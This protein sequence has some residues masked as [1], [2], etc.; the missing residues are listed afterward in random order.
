MKTIK[1]LFF[2]LALTLTVSCDS[3]VKAYDFDADG[4]GVEEWEILDYCASSVANA[5][6]QY[7]AA[8]R[9]SGLDAVVAEGGYTCIIP[10]NDAFK[11]FLLEAGYASFEDVPGPVWREE[12]SYLIFAGDYRLSTMQAGESYTVASL[13]GEEAPI[14]ISR[15]AEEKDYTLTINGIDGLTKITVYS[16]DYLFKNRIVGQMVREM[17]YYRPTTPAASQAP[18][19]FDGD[20]TKQL[21][22]TDDTYIYVYNKN[23]TA[24][25]NGNKSALRI[26]NRKSYYAY[27]LLRFPM[28][29]QKVLDRVVK[30]ELVMKIQKLGTA[31]PAGTPNVRVSVN[32]IN[33]AACGKWTEEDATWDSVLVDNGLTNEELRVGT[34]YETSFVSPE[35]APSVAAP[36][37]VV[38]DITES[39][40]AHKNDPTVE[41]VLFNTSD[42]VN[43]SGAEFEIMDKE[44]YENDKNDTSNPP[45]I[46][47]LKGVEVPHFEVAAAQPLVAAVGEA[48][49]FNSSTLQLA[50]LLTAD[51]AYTR[52]ENL[53]LTLES[54]PE[55]GELTRYGIPMRA[56]S[57]FSYYEMEHGFVKYIRVAE[58]VDHFAVQAADYAGGMLPE[59]VVVEVR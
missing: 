41:Y 26:Y 16:Q 52:P 30:A 3:L 56:G 37:E 47:L 39:I 35:T 44:P 17:P 4:F 32:E 48:V 43:K 19:G 40:L 33:E 25:F 5:C 42:V 8:M 22:P 14:T 6:D 18:D 45:R 9:L 2:L 34:T 50:W 13:R 46:R 29:E 24:N 27:G 28:P 51:P 7:S 23:N 21:E 58:G 36:Y 59:A 38:V 55:L 53:V 31:Y 11:S 12:L 49:C 20:G 57:R 10:N 54:C 1:S 15:A